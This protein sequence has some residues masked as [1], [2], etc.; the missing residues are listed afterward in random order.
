[1]LRLYRLGAQSLWVDEVFTWY[2]IGGG[3]WVVRP[4]DLFDQLHGPLHALVL[5]LWTR[6]AGDSEWALRLPSAVC[7]IATVP[8]LAWLAGRWLGREVAPWAAWLAAVSPF[9]VWYSQEA[10]NYA[11]LMLCAV[12]ASG[13]MVALVRSPEPRTAAGWAAATAAGLLSGWAYALLLPAHAVALW[14][15]AAG[16]ARRLGLGAVAAVVVLVAV[17]PWM[18]VAR[19]TWDWSR[20]VPARVAP[21][22]ETPLRGATTFHAGAVPFALHA[23]AV[24][25]TLGPTLRELRA[26]VSA[27]TLA[28]HAPGIAV[29]TL[30][31]GALGIAG[32]RAVR[33]RGRLLET[34]AW[35]V[36]PAALLSWL[37]ASNFKVFHPRYLMVCAPAVLLVCAAGLADLPRRARAVLALAV[38]GLWALS[39]THHYAHP[40]YGKED[41]RGMV[42]VLRARAAADERIL[43]LN[44]DDPLAYYYRGPLPVVP[45]WLGFA[46][47]PA[48]L[49]AA[50]DAALA[51]ARGAWVVLSRPEDLDP[52]GAFARRLEQRFPDAERVER[53]GIVMWHVRL[54]PAGP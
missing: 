33:R 35:L 6:V 40:R 25:T 53:E 28:P 9:L 2:S 8:A 47:R 17:A 32:L 26:G 7:G 13:A 12:L 36:V 30:V 16:R 50:M 22:G 45:V 41:H 52:V 14:G 20:L 44:T 37:A 43:S 34:L 18:P 46:S 54:R 38:A 10:R 27:R 15:G 21:A 51:G 3:G 39:L 42:E 48:R 19:R 24:G 23:F 31:F 1:V 11:Q 49:D 5:H 29:V 4:A